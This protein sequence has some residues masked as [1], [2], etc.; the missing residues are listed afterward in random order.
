MTDT[1][2]LDISI[3]IHWVLFYQMTNQIN[4]IVTDFVSTFHE[5]KSISMAEWHQAINMYM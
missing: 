2:V 4:I 3:L 1:F 5:I